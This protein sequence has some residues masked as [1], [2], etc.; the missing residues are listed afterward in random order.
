MSISSCH[1]PRLK[2]LESDVS[3]LG[4]S[5]SWRL[6]KEKKIPSI[7]NERPE[8]HDGDFVKVLLDNTKQPLCQNVDVIATDRQRT[9]NQQQNF[10]KF[11][12]I[13]GSPCIDDEDENVNNSKGA[14]APN[15]SF[16]EDESQRAFQIQQFITTEVT[17]VEKLRTL[18]NVIAQPLKIRA[19]EKD[20][21]TPLNTF[22][23]SKIFINIDEIAEAN[24]YFLAD[25]QDYL[26]G[27]INTTFGDICATHAAKFDCYRKYLLGKTEAQQFQYKEFKSNQAYR[28]FLVKAIEHPQ[29]KGCHSPLPELLIEP[30]QRIGRYTMMLK[31]VLR[32]TPVTHPDFY[33]LTKALSKLSEIAMMTDDDPT[34]LANMFHTLLKSIKDTPDSIMKQ[35]RSLVAHLDA[36][37]IHRVSNKTLRPVTIFLFTDLIMVA[38]RPSYGCKAIDLCAIDPDPKAFPDVHGSFISRGMRKE[39]SLK[40]KGWADIEQ[41]EIFEGA[42]GKV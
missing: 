21:T 6:T 41:V 32:Y 17:Y 4:F 33:G 11:L 7:I 8:I 29:Y 12:K 14:D 36:V 24:E 35:G 22:L 28:S 26:K 19:Q 15:H 34:K 27:E 3:S 18:V 25:L 13:I 40:F 37:E 16:V 30:V 5:N 31:D 39:Q 42:R 20:K 9:Q 1:I 23:C 10:E 2:V 38:A